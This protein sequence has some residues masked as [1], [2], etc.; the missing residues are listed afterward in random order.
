[1]YKDVSQRHGDFI[2]NM[3]ILLETWR[4]VKILFRDIEISF[5]DMYKQYFFIKNF[6]RFSHPRGNT[7]SEAYLI[8]EI[9]RGICRF[10]FFLIYIAFPS[11]QSIKS[12]SCQS[13]FLSYFLGHNSFW[14]HAYCHG[15]KKRFVRVFYVHSTLHRR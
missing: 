11:L 5:R 12:D 6:K 13:I 9:H 2:R 14:C 10:L 4:S 8:S 7:I 1:M 15:E 3:E